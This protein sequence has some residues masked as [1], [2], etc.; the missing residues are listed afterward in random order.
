M[1]QRTTDVPP[2]RPAEARVPAA[3]APGGLTDAAA[4]RAFAESFADQAIVALDRDGRVVAWNAGAERLTGHAADDAVGQSIDRL[5]A[6]DALDASARADARR[7]RDVAST[8][9]RAEHE[10]WRTRKDGSR[11]WAHTVVTRLGAADDA[12]DAQGAPAG[13]A[14]VIR[15]E[16]DRRVGADALAES[17]TL[18]ADRERY[19]QAVLDTQPE[20]VTVVSPGGALLDVNAAGLALFEAD[21]L[22]ELRGTPAR[23]RVRAECRDA[24]D[25]RHTA[26][27]GGEPGTLECELAG[28]R[29][30]RPWVE[31]RAVPLRDG[32]G[33]VVAVLW[34]TRDV[35]VPRAAE[36]LRRSEELFHGVV[37]LASDAIITV[38]E[39]QRIV[40][41]NASA[42]GAFGYLAA[43]VLGRSLDVLL[44]PGAGA[45]P[46]LA[47]LP[48]FA[49]DETRPGGTAER[50]EVVGRRRGGEEFPAEVAISRSTVDGAVRHTAIVRDVSAQRRLD[51]ALRAAA[52]ELARS[53][54]ELE[55]FASVASHDLQEPLRMVS[56]YTQLLANRYGGQLDARADTYIGYAVDGAR[57][58]QV[59]I[60]DLLTLSRVGKGGRPAVAVD[61]GAVVGATLAT[62]VDTVRVTGAR[63]RV[64]PLPA[65]LGDAGQLGQ[66]FQNLL[67]NALKFARPGCPPEVA[68]T[69]GAPLA[70]GMQ[71]F[72]VCDRGIGLEARHAER[73]FTMFQRLHTRE[74]YPG[75]GIGLAICKKI[76]ERH[77]G[78]IWVE[79]VVGQGTTCHF[80]LPGAR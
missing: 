54:A 63:V 71:P 74:A 36:A 27:L 10:G 6:L 11:Y 26:A 7:T 49:R 23:D 39:H 2:T 9:G 3:R 48:A 76:V 8:T 79:S 4:Y 80:T 46:W 78:R 52:D 30:G 68:V 64:G 67:G 44:P 29:G 59:L 51:A 21:D 19:L 77:G 25:A 45:P 50:R 61:V 73:I 22:A 42:E 1:G 33:R 60:D 56:S 72:A 53:N 20:C 70:G 38:D 12:Q 14:V 65:V 15:D 24:F 31:A 5:D 41:F 17:H 18:F 57:R 66:L 32:T 28:R 43:D 58:M 47:A 75:T 34:V 16:T 55:Q 69:A 13:L 62:L 40:L 37:S 35:T